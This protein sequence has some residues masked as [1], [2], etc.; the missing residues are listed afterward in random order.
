MKL[1][2]LIE[3]LKV[4][5]DSQNNDIDVVIDMDEC[6]YYGVISVSVESDEGLLLINIKSTNEN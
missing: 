3:E 1:R 6:G 2:Q 4:L 5:E